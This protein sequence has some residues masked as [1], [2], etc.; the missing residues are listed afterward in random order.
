MKGMEVGG[1][2]RPA[3]STQWPIL[4][5]LA[6]NITNKLDVSDYCFAHSPPHLNTVATLSTHYFVKCRSIILA[7]Y[8]SEFIL[9]I[10]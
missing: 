6:Y 9:G 3:N 2:G 7:V 1:A 5:V 4:I 8:Y 10:A